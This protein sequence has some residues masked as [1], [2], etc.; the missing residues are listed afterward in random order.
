MKKRR[1]SSV[2]AI[3]YHSIRKKKRKKNR[4]EEVKR[5]DVASLGFLPNHFRS[6]RRNEN[7]KCNFIIFC[8]FFFFCR[9]F[10]H[11]KIS[12]N[13]F[14][15]DVELIFLR[16]S[17]SC[18]GWRSRWNERDQSSTR[19]STFEFS[20][21]SVNP[22]IHLFSR[23]LSILDSDFFVELQRVLEAE[24]REATKGF[25]EKMKNDRFFEKFHLFQN[26]FSMW[27]WFNVVFI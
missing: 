4:V 3:F 16:Q 2:W 27:R 19:F 25:R 11:V 8:R 23:E 22:S 20:S 24:R 5:S 13:S 26:R 15:N 6:N 18:R 14:P 17:N 21:R 9:R 1:K 10:M 12:F 7:F